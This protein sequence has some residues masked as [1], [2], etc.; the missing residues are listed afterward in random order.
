MN[1]M[2]LGWLVLVIGVPLNL[3]VVGMLLRKSRARPDLRVLR[4]RFITAV[5]I[6][7]LVLVYG[8]IFVNNDTIP[9]PF[10]LATTKLITRLAM[11]GLAIVP[12]SIW[13]WLYRKQR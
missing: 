1:P 2:L 7:A 4:E 5:V 8:L 13:L 11:L 12:A 3:F 10:D 9:P 6:L